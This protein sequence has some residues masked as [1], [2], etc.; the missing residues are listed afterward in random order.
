MPYENGELVVT[1]LRLIESYGLQ[2]VGTA[3]LHRLVA[4]CAVPAVK[5]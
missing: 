1:T 4:N 2:P 5:A 3:L